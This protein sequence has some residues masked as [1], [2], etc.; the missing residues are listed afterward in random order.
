MH[1]LPKDYFVRADSN[2]Y[3]RSHYYANP[4]QYTSIFHEKVGA[5]LF[6][7][8]PQLTVC[9]L[10]IAPYTTLLVH[11]A[12][13]AR[14]YPRTM[15]NEQLRLALETAQGV[16]PGRFTCVGDISCDIEGGLE[17]LPQHSTLS[18]PSFST[19]PAALPAHLR[20]VT[21]MAVDILPTA[22]PRDASQHF[23]R[24]LLPYLRTVI[25]GYH[26]APVVDGG[27]RGRAEALERAT[28]AK[29]GV[30]AERHRWLEDGPLGAWRAQSRVVKSGAGG[31]PA[32]KKVLMLGS[33]MVAGPAVD[34]IARH[35]D[36]ELVVGKCRLRVC[37]SMLS[38]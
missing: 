20:D 10:K 19:R 26:G 4:D 17:F 13:W 27:E 9:A 32:R 22:L 24:V 15:T 35:G 1:A 11:G 14:G 29:G 5:E 6:Q 31:A 30:L 16:G 21:V 25:G 23:A 33:G 37:I 34:E 7:L 38:N 36:V 28:T 3:E 2:P 8:G 18:A 12:G